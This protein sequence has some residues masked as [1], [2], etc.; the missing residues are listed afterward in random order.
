[1]KNKMIGLGRVGFGIFFVMFFFYGEAF[2]Q[3]PNCD[4]YGTAKVRGVPIT[5]DETIN[6]YDAG[7]QF[8]G[9][10]YYIGSGSYAIHAIG[11]DLSTPGV[12][13]GAS[14]GDAISF[15]IDGEAAVVTGGSNVWH[16]LQS[17]ECNIDVPDVPPEADPGDPISAMRGVPWCLT[18]PGLWARL[19]MIGTLAM[20]LPM[21]AVC[22]LHMPM[23]IMQRIR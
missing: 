1:M 17:Y 12:D 16:N 8:C 22:L 3:A 4:F 23:R 15:R 6:A 9:T 18:D 21:G 20:D 14:E 7:G 13:E 10:T 2:P 5:G 11:D 19:I